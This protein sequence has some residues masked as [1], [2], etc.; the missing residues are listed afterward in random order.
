MRLA[1]SCGT[2]LAL[3]PL[4]SDAA[5][6]PAH[7]LLFLALNALSVACAVVASAVPPVRS[8]RRQLAAESARAERLVLDCYDE[9]IEALL[10]APLCRSSAPASASCAPPSSSSSLGRRLASSTDSAR[11]LRGSAAE[12]AAAAAAE[13]EEATGRRSKARASRRR[14]GISPPSSARCG[15]APAR[16]AGRAARTPR[17]S[18]SLERRSASSPLR[19]AGRTL[20][21]CGGHS[22]A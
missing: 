14:S 6:R 2:I 12:A 7:T 8:A 3:A 11:T 1:L 13:E 9:L 18:R 15:E 21:R 19:C 16:A 22:L 5:L 17:S 10:R 4:G 20:R